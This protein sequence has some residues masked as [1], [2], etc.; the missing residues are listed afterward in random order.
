MRRVHAHAPASG[1]QDQSPKAVARARH[2]TW[3]VRTI[4]HGWREHDKRR[5]AR[6]PV[7]TKGHGTHRALHVIHLVVRRHPAVTLSLD[8]KYWATCPSSCRA[9]YAMRILVRQRVRRRVLYAPAAA[10]TLR[11]PFHPGRCDIDPQFRTSS[12][13][14]TS[15]FPWARSQCP[16]VPCMVR[17]DQGPLGSSIHLVRA[18]AVRCARI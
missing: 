1:K 9:L 17:Q 18:W 11:C 14:C 16:L 2:L 13:R 6:G 3:G 7:A 10:W 4:R 15:C 12:R 5:A 8:I